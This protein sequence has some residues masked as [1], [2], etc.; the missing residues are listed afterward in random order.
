MIRYLV[1][2]CTAAG[3]TGMRHFYPG[4][5]S[6]P[7]VTLT[8]SALLPA[9]YAHNDYEHTYPLSEAL[10]KGFSYLEVDVW[11]IGAELYVSH[12][13]PLKGRSERTFRT[14]Y[15]QPLDDMIRRQEG[16]SFFSDD[17]P[18]NLVVDIKS[19][20][21]ETYTELKRQLAPYRAWIVLPED[22]NQS[23]GKVRIILSGNR[24][25]EQVTAE[26]DRF[27]YLDGR[28]EDLGKGYPADLMPMV[29]GHY[30]RIFGW[31]LPGLMPS[32]SD[33]QRFRTFAD[34]VH[35]ENKLIRLWA[36]P[37]DETVWSLLLQN[38]ADLINTDELERYR[39]FRMSRDPGILPAGM[40]AH[41][42]E[43]PTCLSASSGRSGAEQMQARE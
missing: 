10:A 15:L 16:C 28:F 1:L 39:R 31:N 6:N 12:L 25:I 42:P 38:G 40:A 7:V 36:S 5:Y 35:E 41:L 18:L 20:A 43:E 26:A 11:L 9:A 19:S 4:G 24:P 32:R 30:S 29:S 21:S 22:G 3:F 23:S 13:P 17:A 33:W 37:E 34:R 2:L 14:L 8:P 27:V